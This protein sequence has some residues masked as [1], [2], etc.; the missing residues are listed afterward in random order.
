M[1]KNTVNGK[2]DFVRFVVA[3]NYWLF[4]SI[5]IFM[6]GAFAYQLFRT[7][8]YDVRTTIRLDTVQKQGW[9]AK[10]VFQSSVMVKLLRSE[11]MIR[12]ADSASKSNA[13]DEETNKYLWVTPGKDSSTWTLH[14]NTARP[15]QTKD[16]LQQLL[17]LT[18]KEYYRTMVVRS[19][20]DS[21]SM[22]SAAIAAKNEERTRLKSIIR[23]IARGDNAATADDD[24]KQKDILKTIRPYLNNADRQYQLIPTSFPIKNPYISNLIFQFNDAQSD[25]QHQLS[26]NPDKA[27]IAE[28][29][30]KIIALK[31]AL[32]KVI[33]STESSSNVVTSLLV[34]TLGKIRF[35]DS[36]LKIKQEIDD[37]IIL[38]AAVFQ[39]KLQFEYI[40][41][42]GKI[43]PGYIA[44]FEVIEVSYS[45]VS[46]YFA[47][48]LF[49]LLSPLAVMFI[50][51]KR[52]SNAEYANIN[53]E[54]LVLGG[55]ASATY[56]GLAGAIKKI[57][58]S[59]ARGNKIILI[60]SLNNIA[61]KAEICSKIALQLSTSNTRIV[62]IDIDFDSPEST[63]PGFKDFIFNNSTQLADII[64]TT[65]YPG[66][67]MITK[68]TECFDEDQKEL[69]F[70]SPRFALLLEKLAQKFD[71]IL[72][73]TAALNTRVGVLPLNRFS[74]VNV[75]IVSGLE[76][77]EAEQVC[78]QQ[79]VVKYSIKG[80][81][82]I[83]N[84]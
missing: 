74:T 1:S 6:L 12:K 36:L 22:I 3:H 80:T 42:K 64:V 25:K 51:F 67:G 49:G 48:L 82:V 8:I 43:S 28:A 9:A 40:H 54:I 59:L 78:L 4:S 20:N 14:L 52:K 60:T 45:P 7:P 23:Q 66:V 32:Q 47:A 15:Q 2:Y 46:W 62:I 16:F 68:G 50:L 81:C 41:L 75:V 56:K 79:L 24:Q 19:F 17:N 57:A 5:M 31:N 27:L 53:K 84:E 21:L 72:L 38:Y 73:N 70:N 77:L 83:I 63:H 44:N 18:G 29:N 37:K 39:R 11:S 26:E 61:N 30:K 65:Q 76:N 58:A 55:F 33:D 10:N 69:L 71:Y 13:P 34:K 35:T